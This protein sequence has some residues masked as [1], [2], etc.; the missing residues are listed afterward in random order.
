M[1]YEPGRRCVRVASAHDG[2]SRRARGRADRRAS[3]RRSPGRASRRSRIW[4]ARSSPRRYRRPLR[5]TAPCGSSRAPV[6]A[7]RSSSSARS[8]C[9]CFASGAGRSRSA[10]S[11]RRSSAGRRRSRP[12]SARSAFRTRST[13]YVR[14]DKTPFGQALLS[15]LRFAWLGGGRGDLYTFLRS[16]YSGLDAPERRLP[17]GPPARARAC[18]RRSACEEET[19]R[20]RDGQP[21]PVAR[22]S[23]RRADTARRSRRPRGV[24]AA[25][26]LRS[27]GA[28][29]R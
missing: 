24:H 29:R 6:S 12:P 20:L 4:S 25:L 17:R 1:P 10:S 16:P 9:R 15:L 13:A 19:M 18:R 27:R 14:L 23:A 11:A 2:G 26:R 28:A 7:A 3:C 8:C 5:S 21:L 22:G